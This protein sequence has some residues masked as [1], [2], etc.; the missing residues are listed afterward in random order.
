MKSLFIIFSHITSPR[1]G[2]VE[3]D[4]IKLNGNLD[5]IYNRIMKSQLIVINLS[6]K[7]KKNNYILE[8]FITFYNIPENLLKN[9]LENDK[10]EL[11][12]DI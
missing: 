8:D 10:I 9:N 5:L 12:K 6:K 2:F 1:K 3:I 4:S 11:E 7:E